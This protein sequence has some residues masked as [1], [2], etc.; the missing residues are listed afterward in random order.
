M[1][2]INEKEEDFFSM[3]FFGLWLDLRC[4]KMTPK[5]LEIKFLKNAHMLWNDIKSR[6]NRNFEAN[7]RIFDVLRWCAM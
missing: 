6:R 1:T 7:K 4:A 2:R 3:N 5:L